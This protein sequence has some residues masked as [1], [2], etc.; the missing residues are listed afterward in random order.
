[1]TFLKQ[2]ESCLCWEETAARGAAHVVQ[3]QGLGVSPCHIQ[4]ESSQLAK[5]F[6][7]SVCSD[8]S[9]CLPAL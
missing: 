3:A 1:M 7:L 8:E 9:S 2:S 6:T 4:V 5:A